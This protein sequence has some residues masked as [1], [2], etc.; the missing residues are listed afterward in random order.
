[1]KLSR[2]NIWVK[3]Y[4]QAGD[5]LLFNSRTQALIRI[6]S[7]FKAELDAFVSGAAAASC[8]QVSQ[9]SAALR[10][11]GI[12]VEDEQEE[13]EKLDDFFRQLK[14]ESC[15][16]SFETTILTTYSCNFKCV[17]CF[18]EQVKENVFLNA[19]TSG[20]I[21][22][23]LIHKAK[24]GKFRTIHL[25]YY[26]GEPLLNPA[27]IYNISRKLF[28][29]AQDE[30]IKF[31]FSI[32]SNG[33]LITPQLVGR[34]LSV[35]LKEIRVTIDGDR[36]AHNLKRPFLDG[37]GSFDAIINNIKKVID[38]V[39]IG[40][41]G[42]FDRQSFA[43]IPRLLDYLEEEGVLYQLSSINFAPIVPRL[44]PKSDPGAIE[45]V[46]C[47]SFI[48][49]EGMFKETIALKKE[50]IRRGLKISTG[51][52]VNACPL[53]MQSAGVTID[54][55]G[56]L[57]KCNSLLGH[58]EFSVGNVRNK[59][60]NEKSR[61]FFELDAWK[62][63]PADCAYVPMCQGGCRFFSYVEN[64][65]FTDLSCKRDYFDYIIP[66]LIKLEYEKLK[67]EAVPAAAK[68]V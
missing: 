27:P 40:I 42:N 68:A 11:N 51:L 22:N 60:Y 33:S 38:K 56:V 6:S 31:G 29:W 54:P 37:S 3:D 36:Q 7:Q 53:F 43:S 64:G 21:V 48:G 45:L 26:G 25:V 47:G 19:E 18:E 20:L 17:Y 39:N 61:E 59:A 16:L 35:G 2:F 12:I 50:L 13:Q 32:I 55:K 23:W 62:K 67:T 44:G 8:V 34:L 49:K 28:A 63:C 10:K 1:M 57:Y 52:A 24:E 46:E 15:G 9:N 14:H 58:P 41:A 30:G 5:Y 65:N 4:P 66:E